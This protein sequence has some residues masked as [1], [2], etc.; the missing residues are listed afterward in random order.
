MNRVILAVYSV[1]MW[2]AQPLLRRKLA[3]RGRAEP[4]Y[5]MQ[6]EERF[7][8]YALDVPPA[9]QKLALEQG[10]VWVHA[11]SLG[12]TRVAGVLIEALRKRMPDI[13][14]LLTHG[15][16][17]GRAEGQ[18]LLQT[19]DVQVWQAWDSPTA[20]GRFIQYF[21]PRLGILMETELW[22]NMADMCAKCGIPLVMVN[23]RLSEKSYASTLKF[24][25]LARPAYQ[26]LTAV[27]AQSASDAQRF[28]SLGA[29]VRGVYGNIKF[30]ASVDAAQLARG[31]AWRA[32]VGHPVLMF[33]SSR[34]GVELQLLEYLNKDRSNRS[35]LFTNTACAASKK[36]HLMGL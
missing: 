33:A 28:E 19:G 30:D 22:P 17:T 31:R 2:C 29:P 5:L 14:L 13:K 12:E 6:V 15:T 36:E 10:F 35:L 1:V 21:K 27:W 8:Y 16:A 11:V 4:G 25:W 23:A 9:P 32:R 26:S 34:E 24:G 3:R 7:G 20:V 18:R